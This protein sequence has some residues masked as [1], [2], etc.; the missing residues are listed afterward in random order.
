MQQ[1]RGDADT[2]LTTETPLYPRRTP[3]LLGRTC[4]VC[5]ERANSARVA[6]INQL[7]ILAPLLWRR[8]DVTGAQLPGTRLTLE[9]VGMMPPDFLACGRHQQL[10]RLDELREILGHDLPDDIF[11]H[12]EVVVYDLVPHPDDVVPGNFRVGRGELA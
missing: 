1:H 2:G 7:R 12:A 8:P 3:P 4:T 6:I 10:E 11:V 9:I 5:D